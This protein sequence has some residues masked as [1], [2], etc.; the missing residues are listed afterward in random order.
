ML[1]VA[2]ISLWETHMS[3]DSHLT[4]A[5]VRDMKTAALLQYKSYNKNLW[6]L[7][8]QHVKMC[9]SG[10]NDDYSAGNIYV[11]CHFLCNCLLFSDMPIYI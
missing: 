7:S 10:H 3:T 2:D 8:V 11:F 4:Y 1:Q 5:H 9:Q 6:K